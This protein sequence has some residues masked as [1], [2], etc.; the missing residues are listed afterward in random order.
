[1]AINT[2]SPDVT[3]EEA[4]ELFNALE[5]SGTFE[6]WQTAY[7]RWGVDVGDPAEIIKWL[8][9]T[10]GSRSEKY[11]EIAKSTWEADHNAAGKI[12]GF[13]ANFKSTGSTSFSNSNAVKTVT[14]KVPTNTKIETVEG[15]ERITSKIGL[16]EAGK[17]TIGSVVPALAATGIGITLGKTID[18]TLYNLNPDFWDSHNMSSLD[19]D[20]WNNITS[21]SD[22]VAGTLFD[23][24]FGLDGDKTQAY[25]DDDAFTYLAQYLKSVGFFDPTNS[26]VEYSTETAVGE[27][28]SVD[29]FTVLTVQEAVSLI[30][31]IGYYYDYVRRL[32]EE[33]G[34][35]KGVL[36]NAPSYAG[37]VALAINSISGPYSDSVITGNDTT[38]KS[39]SGG[40]ATLN[41]NMT[42]TPSAGAF[43]AG[44]T[45]SGKIGIEGSSSYGNFNKV[46]FNRNS[47]NF[48]PLIDVAIK[49][50]YIDGVGDQTGANLPDTSS[51]NNLP[52]TKQSL[53]NQYP[54]L[55]DGAKHMD[56][57]DEN[58]Q[59][60][61][62]TLIPINLPNASNPT[63]NQPTSGNRTQTD[64]QIDPDTATEDLIKTITDIITK[65]G[66]PNPPET[67]S[68]DSPAT[69]VPT[70]RASSL[71]KIY[72]PT[73]A[74]VDAF[75]SWLWSSDFVDQIKKLFNDPMQGI[76]GIHKVFASPSIGGSA[77]I[78]VGYLDSQVSSDWV[79]NQYTT[80]NCGSV[81]LSE[82]FGNVFDYAPYTKVSLYLPFIG[83]VDLDVADVMRSTIS[84]KY[85]VDVLSG[86]CLADVKVSRDLADAVLYQYSGSAIVTYPVSSGNY[87]GMVAG[88][89]SVASGVA[90]TILSGG[91]LAPALIGGAVGASHL[92][93]D[94]SHSGGFSGCAGAMAGK[95][96]YLIVSRPITAMADNYGHF[97][98]KPANSHVI[99]RDCSG[100]TKVKSVY[101]GAM[102]SATDEEKD[103]IE[104]QLKS[105]VL[106]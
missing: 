24:V 37:G 52:A 75:G 98:G 106:I 76:I 102:S 28:I 15:A 86:A 41:N 97:T 45:S 58:G 71:W 2:L 63:D 92:H 17:F 20:T 3:Y 91:A 93:T 31:H 13:S 72:N 83:I 56:Y 57:V 68:G 84:V 60:Q 26:S 100:M 74:Q 35:T 29:S 11:V 30:P 22:G 105:G 47:S 85:H 69:V 6:Q 59:N 9:D 88:V 1:M 44:S 42:K 96:P 16:R 62:K 104:A 51:W 81:K 77:T 39:I 66:T 103:I 95:K 61:H 48:I 38:V 18:S 25:I 67:G 70:G 8:N 65:I 36:V 50:E 89:L 53:Q 7:A 80:V 101:V 99:L 34:S 4:V 78:K 49:K 40:T 21:D 64:P 19:P 73:Q 5:G 82:Y 10:Q 87:M 54:Q 32:V 23:L 12:K 46:A 79:D 94:V 33:H 55:W 14:Y 90:G 27:A 43:L